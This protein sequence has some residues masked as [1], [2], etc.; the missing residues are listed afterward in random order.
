MRRR[1]RV[2]KG[3]IG[4]VLFLALLAFKHVSAGHPQQ[5]LLLLL[6]LLLL[7]KNTT[8]LYTQQQQSRQQHQLRC[9]STFTA[10]RRVEKYFCTSDRLR[11]PP[12]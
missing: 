7:L 3:V 2:Y 11:L 10:A 1:R 12:S 9:A 5:R 8:P 6:L 4:F